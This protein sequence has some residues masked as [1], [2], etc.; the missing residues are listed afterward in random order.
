MPEITQ[1]KISFS[2]SSSVCMDNSFDPQQPKNV[3]IS[4]TTN[5][6]TSIHSSLLLRLFS[7]ELSLQSYHCTVHTN[8]CLLH[9]HGPGWVWSGFHLLRSLRGILHRHLPPQKY[10]FSVLYYVWCSLC[11]KPQVE[12]VKLGVWLI[13][14][15]VVGANKFGKRIMHVCACIKCTHNNWVHCKKIICHSNTYKHSSEM[16]SG[17]FYCN[18]TIV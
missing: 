13:K 14:V 8:A 1:S 18:T 2:L 7:C 3:I 16:H 15:G 17:C 4:Y 10:D 5:S 11:R 6:M 12:V 9:A